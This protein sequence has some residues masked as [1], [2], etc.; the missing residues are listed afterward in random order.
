MLQAVEPPVDAVRREQLGVASVLDDPA[1]VQHVDA[2]D[3]LDR[4]QPVRDHQR[5]LALHQHVDA[6]LDQC[7][8]TLEN[9]VQ[10]GA[11]LIS[12]AYLELRERISQMRGTLS[13]LRQM[14]TEALAEKQESLLKE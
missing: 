12:N 5:G 9:S 1:L 2:V 10:R 11:T 8:G 6:L 4:G 14:P 13:T 3:V 7:E